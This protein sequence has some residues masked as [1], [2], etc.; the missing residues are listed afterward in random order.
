MTKTAG[1]E[2]AARFIAR[3]KAELP[4]KPIYA[5]DI[6]REARL[7]W[8][9]EAVT[10]RVQSNHP[11]KVFM[12]ERLRLEGIVGTPLRQAG[13]RVGDVEYRFGYYTV[14]RSDK[15]WWGQ[16]ALLSPLRTL[17]RF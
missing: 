13:A 17:C 5:K 2:P 3:K 8:R 9:R 11:Q 10:L 14:S 6:G 15:W 12:I 16:Y 7:K 1:A 4:S